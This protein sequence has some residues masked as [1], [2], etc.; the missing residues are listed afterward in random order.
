MCPKALQTEGLGLAARGD[1]G[2]G[3][4]VT[5]EEAFHEV[6]GAAGI[7][8]ADDWVGKA[9]LRWSCYLIESAGFR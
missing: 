1:R 8:V 7:D 3:H 5:T 6:P 2:Y 4:L 9:R